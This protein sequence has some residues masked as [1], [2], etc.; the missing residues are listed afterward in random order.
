MTSAARLMPRRERSSS[1]LDRHIASSGSRRTG[2]AEAAGQFARGDASYDSVLRTLNRERRRGRADHSRRRPA[3]V[4]LRR[5]RPGADGSLLDGKTP[6]RGQRLRPRSGPRGLVVPPARHLQ[7][8]SPGGLCPARRD[9]DLSGHRG[10]EHAAAHFRRADHPGRDRLSAGRARAG[11][12]R[13]GAQR[14]RAQGVSRVL[15]VRLHHGQERRQVLPHPA[16][17]A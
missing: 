12:R 11:R 7:P 4:S 13:A 5:S 17:A 6:A 1:W 2:H 16:P 8:R 9:R 10:Q 15:P 3:Q 14:R